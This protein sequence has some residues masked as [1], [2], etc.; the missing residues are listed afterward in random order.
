MPFRIHTSIKDAND[1]NAIICFKEIDD[2]RPEAQ[3]AQ[4]AVFNGAADRL[5]QRNLAKCCA[6]FAEVGFGLRK[7]PLVD[8]IGADVG[9]IANGIGQQDQLL[10]AA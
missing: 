10:H 1:L 2:M 6:H 3:L 8:R 9:Q 4:V 7:A 5:P